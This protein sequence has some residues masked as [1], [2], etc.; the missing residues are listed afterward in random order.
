MPARAR[1]RIL[2]AWEVGANLGHAAKIARVVA[3]LAGRAEAV[4]AAKDPAAFRQIAP[5]ADVVLLPAPAA[6]PQ[7][8]PAG[9]LSPALSY[10][11][12]VSQ[13]GW[14]DPAELAA[15][16]E[17]WRGLIGFVAPDALAC[18]A[19]PTALLAAR[20]RGLRTM[21]F[22]TG[23][24]T[25]P[26]AVPMPPFQFW[27]PGVEAPA[28][29]REAAVVAAANRA[30]ARIGGPPLDAFADLLR[31]DAYMLATAPELDHYGPRD[32]FEAGAGDYV[33]PLVETSA[34][35]A[36]DWRP[37]AAIRAFAY[38]RAPH[39]AAKAAVEALAS[40]PADWDVIVA[41]PG[42][43][44]AIGR[45]AAARLARPGFR[46]V[47]G[48]VRLDRLLP[49]CDVG[50]SHGSSGVAAAFVAAGA[51]QLCLPTHMEQV[52]CARAI[53]A[54]R[55]GLGLIG[56]FGAEQIL[57]GVRQAARLPKLR[58]SAQA[59]ASRLRSEDMLRPGERIAER[60]LDL[61]GVGG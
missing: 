10:P 6:R 40:A 21:M 32:R 9:P 3:G 8:P 39:P 28:A 14:A 26:R 11:D 60:L 47:D 5:E 37:D 7:R 15:L 55:L 16:A 31:T 42:I 20:G 46:L 48:P 51:P 22:G 57:D 53:A 38:V 29:A 41:A 52:M 27:T 30:L 50:V 18:Q 12:D 19:A 33:G 61:V 25:P 45:E 54:N 24:D 13:A 23:Y 4:V 1:P 36:L 35:A 2:F 17:A 34:G 49:A 58:Q 56:G 43:A 44:A 59:L